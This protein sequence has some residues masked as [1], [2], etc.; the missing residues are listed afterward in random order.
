MTGGS[1]DRTGVALQRNNGAL[2]RTGVHCG[3]LLLHYRGLA[4][5]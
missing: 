4:M 5:Q 2:Y 3:G 1:K